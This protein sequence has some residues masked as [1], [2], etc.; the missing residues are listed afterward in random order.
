MT[1]SR[2][3]ETDIASVRQANEAFS[4]G[5]Q[6][7]MLAGRAPD[8]R[9]P[10]L[11]RDLEAHLRQ[12]GARNE[13]R[14][15]HLRRLD[16]HFGREAARRVED[17]VATFDPIEPHLS[18]DRVDGVVTT[19]VLD[20]HEDFGARRFVGCERAAMHGARLLVDRLVQAHAV[21]ERIERRLRQ[22]RARRQAHRVDLLHQVAEH[23]SLA[24]ARRLGALGC[25][26]FEIGQAVACRDGDGVDIPVDLHRDDVLDPLDQPLIAQVSERERFGRGTERHQRQ[27]LLLVDVERQRM[28]AGD[29]RIARR[30]CLIHCMHRERRRTRSVRQQRAIRCVGRVKWS[31]HARG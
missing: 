16:H 8:H 21:E 20:E 9:H 12:A 5:E 23:R 31:P 15:R 3:A 14:N 18:G 13:K 27:Q 2:A 19:D 25:L 7:I 28:L 17:L 26:R 1:L 6:Q 22:R 24:A 10:D 4:A 30:A 29:R 11:L